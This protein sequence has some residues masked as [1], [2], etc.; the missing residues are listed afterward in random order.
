VNISYSSY[1]RYLDCPR[2]YHYEDIKKKPKVEESAY[3][4]LYGL[5]MEAFFKRYTNDLSKSGK[6]LS[7]TGIKGILFKMWEKILDDNYVDWGDPW[8]R[9]T[10]SQIFERAYQDVLKNLKAFSFWGESK[11]EITI[12][13][14][15]KK[16]RD[17]VTGRLDFLWNRPAG[18]VEILDGK[19]TNK[20]ETN[21]DVEQLYFYALLYLLH[22]GRLP[23]KIGF[24]FYRYQII[25]YIDFDMDT[26]VTFK[27]KVSA[28]KK[29]IKADKVFLPKVG[30]SKQCKWCP[31]RFECDA[32]AS[33]RAA[34]A[35]KRKVK[36]EALEN[37]L[38]VIEL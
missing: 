32:Y 2:R 29:L 24:L 12:D 28:V 15:L 20:I 3:F 16:T 37:S 10:S 4:K 5:L 17:L 30:L 8:V 18:G 38:G 14:L 6:E 33:K 22:H 23:N 19:G 34:N 26:I 35:E 7:E 36:I 9:E 25:K 1:R 27:D 13:V 11:S 31:Y 21:V